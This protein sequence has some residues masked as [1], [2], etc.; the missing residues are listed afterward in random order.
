MPAKP[1]AGPPS[2]PGCT[3]RTTTA[4]T[5]HSAAVHRSPA[6]PTS[7]SPTPR[8]RVRPPYP[9]PSHLLA[10]TRNL[11]SC[12]QAGRWPD[13][14]VRIGHRRLLGLPHYAGRRTR[15][16]SRR[17][18]RRPTWE[19]R[20]A[21]CASLLPK[22]TAWSSVRH[23]LI[24]VMVSVI[25]GVIVQAL[26]SGAS[27]GLWIAKMQVRCHVTGNRGISMQ[28]REGQLWWT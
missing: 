15:R 25:C 1:P 8:Q 26:V 28:Q 20:I 19:T 3:G 6:A 18:D 13:P 22:T 7:P 23:E 11:R 10:S 14:L 2:P 27:L 24:G 9:H 21:G 4:P 12:W 17:C 5:A 16:G